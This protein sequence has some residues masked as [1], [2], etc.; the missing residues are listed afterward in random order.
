MTKKIKL[1]FKQKDGT[2]KKFNSGK[3][4]KLPNWTVMKHKTVLEEIHKLPKGTSEVIKDIEFQYWAIYESLKEIDPEL[5]IENIK[6]LHPIVLSQL[7]DA[8]Y[9]EG[10]YDIYFRE[11]GK[12]SKS[13]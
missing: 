11:P 10:K 3:P 13:E 12:K 7:F 9:N 5:D 6:N 2:V 1:E 4:F 8:V